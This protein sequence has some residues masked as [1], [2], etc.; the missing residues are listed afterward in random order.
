[1]RRMQLINYNSSYWVQDDAGY[2]KRLAP[3]EMDLIIGSDCGTVGS[4]KWSL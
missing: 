4:D 2:R 3:A 1:M